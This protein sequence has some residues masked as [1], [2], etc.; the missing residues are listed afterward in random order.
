LQQWQPK[1]NGYPNKREN[2]AERNKADRQASHD[3]LDVFVRRLQQ[4]S[5]LMSLLR[6]QC[7][8]FE[9]LKGQRELQ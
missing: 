8:P 3:L 5:A 7:M 2:D 9:P 6:R 4:I 1:N